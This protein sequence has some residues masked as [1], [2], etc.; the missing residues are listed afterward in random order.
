MYVHVLFPFFRRIFSMTTYCQLII[1][2]ELPKFMAWC[3]LMRAVKARLIQIL[4]ILSKIFGNNHSIY[5]NT[6]VLI[7]KSLAELAVFSCLDPKIWG[8]PYQVKNI[9]YIYPFWVLT[10]HP[11]L[12][13]NLGL[14]CRGCQCVTILLNSLCI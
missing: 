10:T 5:I 11:Y 7:S 14:A 1:M 2:S 12:H 9:L 8:V 4:I 3:K 13:L 6:S